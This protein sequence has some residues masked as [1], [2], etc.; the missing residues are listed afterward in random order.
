VGASVT[1][2]VHRRLDDEQL[3]ELIVAAPDTPSTLDDEHRRALGARFRAVA[4][5]AHRR[6]DAW[7]VERA[8]VIDAGFRWS[9]STAR[10][11]LG[12]AALRRTRVNSS[13]S[14]ADAVRDVVTDQ[15]LRAAAGYARPGSL[16]HWL[17]ATSAG[18]R[19]AVVAEA[20]NWATHVVETTQHLELDWRVADSDAYYDVASARTTL[21]GRRDLVVGQGDLRVLVRFRLASPG[22]S[23]GPGLRSDLTIDALA[24]REG[25]AAARIIGIW[26]EA[27][28][29]LA[30]DG[31][32]DDLR[33]GARDLVRAAVVLERRRTA[34]AA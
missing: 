12:N 26:P 32:M 6:L 27:G 13:L 4:G 23:A 17:A 9:S 21:R 24:H 10:R 30:V 18:E 2:L 28:V 31:T 25:R 8:G 3:H 33:A 34:R 22:K 11:L 29:M 19:G 14:L 20:V 5:T 1:T 16:E 15:L 7:S